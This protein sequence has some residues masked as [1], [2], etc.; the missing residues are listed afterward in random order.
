MTVEFRLPSSSAEWANELAGMSKRV[1]DFALDSSS[2]P[3]NY[4]NA[5]CGAAL[6]NGFPNL[7]RAASD[8]EK[9]RDELDKMNVGTA[10]SR[11]SDS[12]KVAD[13]IWT[14]IKLVRESTRSKAA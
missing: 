10:I 2:L 3:E 1:Q 13:D 6:E 5:L 8:P 4:R 14:A 7:N 11:S 9:F 12:D